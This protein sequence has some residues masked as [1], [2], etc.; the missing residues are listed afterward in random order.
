MNSNTI[1]VSFE[2]SKLNSKEQQIIAKVAK[3]LQTL[4]NKPT[5]LNKILNELNLDIDA[6]NELRNNCDSYI[7]NLENIAVNKIDCGYLMDTVT[8][9]YNQY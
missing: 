8:F 1:F 7:E 9:T 6:R 4:I 3:Y 5:H 2:Y